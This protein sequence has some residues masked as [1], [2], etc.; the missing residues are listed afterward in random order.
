MGETGRPASPARSAVERTCKEV[1]A[2]LRNRESA[3]RTK[4][5][6]LSRIQQYRRFLA[7]G[8]RQSAGNNEQP[9]RQ[10]LTGESISESLDLFF[11]LRI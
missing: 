7:R 11:A 3:A 10:R 2:G 1:R 8:K 5:V 4:A 6:Q 9:T